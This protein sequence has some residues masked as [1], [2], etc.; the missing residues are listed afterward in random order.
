MTVISQASYRLS[1]ATWT[2]ACPAKVF[3][4]RRRKLFVIVDLH[5][6]GTL[7]SWERTRIPSTIQFVVELLDSTFEKRP[8]PPGTTMVTRIA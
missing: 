3:R 2:A 5:V 8:A 7:D 1:S 6:R 4:Y